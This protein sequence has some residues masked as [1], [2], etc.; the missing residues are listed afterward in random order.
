MALVL[1]KS[2]QLLVEHDTSRFYDLITVLLLVYFSLTLLVFFI[3]FI[4]EVYMGNRFKGLTAN[5]NKL[6]LISLFSYATIDIVRR[7]GKTTF[8]PR[9]FTTFKILLISLIILTGS[10]TAL[11]SV[12]TYEILLRLQKNKFLLGLAL[13][14]MFSIYNIGINALSLVELFGLS[15][16]IRLDTIENASGRTEVWTV[17]IQEIKNQPWL[18]KGMLY[19]D[20]F[21]NN[22]AERFIGENRARHW[23]GIWNSYLSLLL[24]VGI[25]GTLAFA[26][27]WY[28]MYIFSQMKNI[29]FAF[30]I[31]CLFSGISES[32]MAASMNAFMPL[33]F[34][35]LALQIYTPKSNTEVI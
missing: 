4:D 9:F 16:F 7:G 25:I 33:I 15:D 23:Y 2:V 1:F 17:A 5:P 32:W 19:D 31:I 35:C 11:F 28:K 22:Y 3:P 6:G 12:F 34:T 30:L 24:N 8:R 26:F 18:G 20:Y 14:V 27:F 13:L 21:I 10:R 29:R